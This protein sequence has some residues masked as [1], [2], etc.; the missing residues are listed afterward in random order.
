M[1]QEILVELTFTEN[2]SPVVSFIHNCKESLWQENED[3]IFKDFKSVH[4]TLSHFKPK[5]FEPL[6]FADLEETRD[7]FIHI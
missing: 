6:S 5:V 3:T 1:L 4:F 7:A 2:G